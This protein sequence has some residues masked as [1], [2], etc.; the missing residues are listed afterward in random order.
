MYYKKATN[1]QILNEGITEASSM[2]D[3]TA[4]ATSYAAHHELVI[5]F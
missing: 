1:A 3:L 4:A 5:P 2:T